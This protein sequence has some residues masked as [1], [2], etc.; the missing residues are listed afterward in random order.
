MNPIAALLKGHNVE[1]VID[2]LIESDKEY[3]DLQRA[4]LE[5]DR[6]ASA[7]LVAMAQRMASQSPQLSPDDVYPGVRVMRLGFNTPIADLSA[8][9]GPHG[10]STDPGVMQIRH[11]S[12]GRGLQYRPV[13]SGG[14]PPVTARAN[15]MGPTGVHFTIPIPYVQSQKLKSLRTQR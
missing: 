5:G 4:A 13:Q 10:T 15:L 1:S 8:H 11:A 14:R 6:E 3:R 2:A 9:G 7:K 12:Q